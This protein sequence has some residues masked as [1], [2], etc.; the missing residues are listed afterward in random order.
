ML[1]KYI[2]GHRGA[3]AVAPENTE[4][5][6]DVAHKLNFDGVELD[7]HQ[8]KDNKIVIIHDETTERT[9]NKN[10]K[11]LDSNLSDLKLLDYGFKIPLKEEKKELK[12]KQTILTLEEFLD[13]FLTLFRFIN[14][15][16]KTDEISYKGI[17]KRIIDILNK[18]PIA[19]EKVILS[20][21][22]FHSL[23]LVY[24]LTTNYKLGF[25]WWKEEEFNK[26]D[27]LLIK[28]ICN[29]LNPWIDLYKVSKLKKEYD[30]LNLLYSIWTINKESEY[31]KLLKDNKVLFLIC[32]YKF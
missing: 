27:P 20:S 28:K 2:L 18:Y 30:K 9:A 31:K 19:K 7:L 14:L 16:I 8:T 15:E 6:F 13:K 1:K 22:N 25:L 17:E 26:I 32:N 21:F 5:A 24:S 29:Y 11:I 10:L 23:E 12:V 4:I 3:Q